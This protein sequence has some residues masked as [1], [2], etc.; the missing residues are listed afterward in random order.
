MANLGEDAV[1]G[2]SVVLF[3]SR[4]EVGLEPLEVYGSKTRTLAYLAGLGWV[5]G[6][7]RLN[8]AFS[9]LV[10]PAPPGTTC[11]WDSPS[12]QTRVVQRGRSEGG[13]AANLVRQVELLGQESQRARLPE[14]SEKRA[15]EKRQRL[16][17]RA[18]EGSS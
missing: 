17:V 3:W 14:R 1:R 4:F 11:G 18:Q 5:S 8:L 7:S 13:A 10:G 15:S 16:E 9:I 12:T 6:E 2:F